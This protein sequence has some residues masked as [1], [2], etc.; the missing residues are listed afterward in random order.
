MPQNQ[1]LEYGFEVLWPC[2]AISDDSTPVTILWEYEGYPIQYEPGHIEKTE[3]NS[4][5]LITGIIELSCSK[6]DWMTH[7]KHEE[8]MNECTLKGRLKLTVM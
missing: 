8:Y 4:L 6:T 1:E 5:K 3:D 7:V 2:A